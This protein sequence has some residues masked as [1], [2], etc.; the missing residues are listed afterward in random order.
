M[1]S[2]VNNSS[3]LE[4]CWKYRNH[5]EFESYPNN[6]TKE[7]LRIA[8]TQFKSESNELETEDGKMNGLKKNDRI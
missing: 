2:F 4:Y 1:C 7:S 8:L 5:F 6:L 3:K